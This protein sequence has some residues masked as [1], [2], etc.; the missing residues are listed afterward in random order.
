MC[1]FVATKVCQRGQKVPPDKDA[2]Q[3]TKKEEIIKNCFAKIN[4]YKCRIAFKT[5]VHHHHNLFF[6]KHE[7]KFL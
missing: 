4:N 6:N 2:L 3:K 1:V 7:L 5:I